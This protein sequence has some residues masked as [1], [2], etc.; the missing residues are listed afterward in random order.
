[1]CGVP[2]S[3]L[4]KD[5][6]PPSFPNKAT[7]AASEERDAPW[8]GLEAQCKSRV[9]RARPQLTDLTLEDFDEATCCWNPTTVSCTPLVKDT[10]MS[11]LYARE[12]RNC[13]NARRVANR[14]KCVETKTLVPDSD[15]A[16][17][18]ECE[19]AERLPHCSRHVGAQ[20]LEGDANLVCGTRQIG[21]DFHAVRNTTMADPPLQHVRCGQ[22]TKS[23]V[24]AIH[25]TTE[26]HG[27]SGSFRRVST[28]YVDGA[29]CRLHLS[30]CWVMQDA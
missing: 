9:Q 4:H 27:C 22:Q 7:M 10:A 17:S 2:S 24:I 28:S 8:L 26:S 13:I 11:P 12:R 21:I 20:S 16:K 6:P 30:I 14:V 5:H 18:F 1:M 29:E 15:L 3:I 19:N 25:K 23:K